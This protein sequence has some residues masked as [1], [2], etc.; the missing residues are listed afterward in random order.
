MAVVIE[1]A[2]AGGIRTGSR[3]R[4]SPVE[5]HGN[6]ETAHKIQ[7]QHLTDAFDPSKFPP[8]EVAKRLGSDIDKG[9]TSAVAAEKLLKDGPNELKKPPAPGLLLLFV[10]QLTGFIIILLM[11]A[12]VASIAVN[13]T[14]KKSGDALSYT[15]GVAI[16]VI[17]FLNA[18]IAAYTEHQAGGALEALAKMSQASV[19]VKRD[20]VVVLVPTISV[21]RGDIV[22]LGT[23]DVVP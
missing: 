8:E 6:V 21:V 3:D 14:G 5:P 12:A 16:F 10:M 9:L 20:G 18:G 22:I 17:V 4:L 13:A 15:T 2:F 23:G 19:N 7:E 11:F 1:T